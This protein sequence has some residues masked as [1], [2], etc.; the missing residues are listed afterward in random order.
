MSKW[1]QQEAIAL[2]RLVERYCPVTGCHVALT[3][4]CLYKDGERNDCDLIFYRIRQTPQINTQK[5]MELL[6]TQVGFD[7]IT[8]GGWRY[9]GYYLGKKVDLLFPEAPASEHDDYPK[10][11]PR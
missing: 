5:L 11:Q 3:G 8:G 6:Q 10:V 1:T 9:V 4:G 2:C 7:H